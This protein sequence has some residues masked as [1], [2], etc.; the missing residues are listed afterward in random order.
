MRYARPQIKSL[1]FFLNTFFFMENTKGV[2]KTLVQNFCEY[3]TIRKTKHYLF[4]NILLFSKEKNA[5]NTSEISMIVS[6]VIFIFA[7][8]NKKFF[9]K[10][11]NSNFH[12]TS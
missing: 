6:L 4:S 12:F 7:N 9:G 11:K 3:K 5:K 10:Y 8:T 1:M 2:D